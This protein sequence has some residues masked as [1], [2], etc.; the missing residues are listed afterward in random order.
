MDSPYLRI[1]TDSQ[2][3]SIELRAIKAWAERFGP[4]DRRATEGRN[5]AARL[6]RELEATDAHLMDSSETC[7]RRVN[8]LVKS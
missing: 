5:A 8:E 1:E 3:D 6:L 4:P 7:M 2:S